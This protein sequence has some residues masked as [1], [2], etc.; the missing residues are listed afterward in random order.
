[1]EV[2]GLGAAGR[3]ATGVIGFGAIGAGA[4]AGAKGLGAL[5]GGARGVIGLGALGGAA[6]GATGLAALGGAATG[7][8]GLAALGAGAAGLDALGGGAAGAAVAALG[9][10]GTAEGRVGEMVTW[11]SLAPKTP[12]TSSGTSTRFWLERRASPAEPTAFRIAARG[13]SI[14]ELS[15]EASSAN[16]PGGEPW[17]NCE[18]GIL[19]VPDRNCFTASEAEKE[20]DPPG[21]CKTSAATSLGSCAMM[22]FSGNAIM[23]PAGVAVRVGAG[24][25]AAGA[26][27]PGGGAGAGART[28]AS[29][30]GAA[31]G[32]GLACL[33][34]IFLK[35]PNINRRAILPEADW[36]VDSK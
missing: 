2:V 5:A 19:T 20:N 34:N 29:A 17:R 25:G 16:V 30:T 36:H 7:A 21:D 32:G 6:T 10:A 33:E 35:T 23:S 31:A 4:A 1:M 8:A 27:V 9:A 18:K 3:G 14:K 12:V 26:E 22:S 15:L 11:R 13:K 24:D 28:G